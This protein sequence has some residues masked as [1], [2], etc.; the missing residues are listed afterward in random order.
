MPT[1]RALQ[2]GKGINEALA[3]REPQAADDARRLSRG[4]KTLPADLPGGGNSVARDK[5]VNVA[6]L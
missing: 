4:F 2:A 5:E 6:Q 1:Q 3:S